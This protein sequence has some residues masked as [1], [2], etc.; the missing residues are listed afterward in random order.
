MKTGRVREGIYCS[1]LH[2]QKDDD[3]RDPDLDDWRAGKEDHLGGVGF[4]PDSWLPFDRF[5]IDR[6]FNSQQMEEAVPGEMRYASYGY[7]EWGDVQ[8]GD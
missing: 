5:E 3:S 7:I 8:I 1:K 6:W 2:L 4:V